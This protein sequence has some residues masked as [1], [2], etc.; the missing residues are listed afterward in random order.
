MYNKHSLFKLNH[1]DI[2][3]TSVNWGHDTINCYKN[4]MLV[5]NTQCTV[6]Q[7]TF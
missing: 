3:N 2:H 5:L 1:I 7:C 6:W 4:I